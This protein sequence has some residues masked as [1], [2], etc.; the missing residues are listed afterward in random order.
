MA[1]QKPK[2]K[3]EKVVDTGKLYTMKEACLRTGLAY[4]TLKFYCN[5]G[6]VP[7]VKRDDRNRRIFNDRDIAWIQSLTCLKRCDMSIAEMQEYLQYCLQGRS[8]I[9]T[10]KE[11]LM[12]KRG[13]LVKRLS[14]VQAA[15]EYIDLKQE[16]YDDVLA[17]RTEYF[18]NLVSQDDPDENEAAHGAAAARR[19]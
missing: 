13:E 6:L 7:S 12:Q 9:P 8:T 1:A 18:S 10:R 15:I 3:I 11:M 14:E 19:S 16:F 17:G 4:E 2:I 5:I